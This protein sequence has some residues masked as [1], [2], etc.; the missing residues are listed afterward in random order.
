MKASYYNYLV[1]NGDNY[2]LYN[3]FSDEI[4][5]MRPEIHSIYVENINCI[6]KIREIHSSFYDCLL[7]KRAIVE[8]NENEVDCF[9]KNWYYREQNTRTFT[10]T[11]NPTLN[12]NMRC[13]YCYETKKRMIMGDSVIQRIIA[14]VENKCKDTQY[15]NIVLSF[16]GGEPLLTLEKII[17]PII[18]RVE[19]ICT[20]HD[21]QLLL[22]YP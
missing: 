11:I 13:W 5:L 3:T 12:C 8:D 14:A 19:E 9:V 4:I 22:G 7:S 21:K 16:F 1:N 6:D 15:E 10:F 2:I 18:N 20:L 17:K